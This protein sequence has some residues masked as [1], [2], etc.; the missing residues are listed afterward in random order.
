MAF[1]AYHFH[2]SKEEIMDM[3]HRERHLWVKEVSGINREINEA[4][5]EAARQA[6]RSA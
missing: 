5:E 6:V 2:W 3:P 1:L 4:A